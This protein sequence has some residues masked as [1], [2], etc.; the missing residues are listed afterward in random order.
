M[1]S[2]A[3]RS[4]TKL[5]G[6]LTENGTDQNP[7]WPGRPAGAFSY[8]LLPLHDRGRSLGRQAQQALLRACWALNMGCYA[9]HDRRL[10]SHALSGSVVTTEVFVTKVGRSSNRQVGVCRLWAARWIS[11]GARG[12]RP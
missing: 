3:R 1:P 5:Q 8:A 6:R 10:L 2:L 12:P 4:L 9:L 11:L 7:S